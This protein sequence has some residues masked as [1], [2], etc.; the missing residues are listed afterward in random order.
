VEIEF[1][2]ATIGPPA[3]AF[4]ED[5]NPPGRKLPCPVPANTVA[6]GGPDTDDP[7]EG[8]ALTGPRIGGP[9]F[10]PCEESVVGGSARGM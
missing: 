7:A 3:G 8:G 5:G 2:I 10:D 9:K 4:V 6:L 1:G